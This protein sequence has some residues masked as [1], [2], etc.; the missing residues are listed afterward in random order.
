MGLRQRTNRMKYIGIGILVLVWIWLSYYV[1]A[2]AGV[3]LINLFW[4]AASA[5]VIFVPLYR[6]YIK[7]E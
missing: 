5:I 1:L 4:I 2:R 6:R 3:N 7:K